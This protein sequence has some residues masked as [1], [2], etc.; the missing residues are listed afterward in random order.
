M[1]TPVCLFSF[2]M[3]FGKKEGKF[4]WLYMA[5]CLLASVNN[6]GNKVLS[7]LDVRMKTCRGKF[8]Q[9]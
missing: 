3:F 6:L 4:H 5:D 1:H 8:P 9:V 7:V 2:D